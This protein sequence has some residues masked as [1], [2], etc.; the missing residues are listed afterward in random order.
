MFYVISRL[1]CLVNIVLVEEEK[2]QCVNHEIDVIII[3]FSTCIQIAVV[4]QL[5]Y[6]YS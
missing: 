5:S 3:Y 6:E 2:R 4:V 1:G